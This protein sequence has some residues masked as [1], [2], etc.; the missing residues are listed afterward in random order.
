MLE[1]W[2][3][4][5]RPAGDQ[6]GPGK[7]NSQTCDLPQDYFLGYHA[8]SAF[9]GRNCK[10]NH[11]LPLVRYNATKFGLRKK[12]KGMERQRQAKGNKGRYKKEIIMSK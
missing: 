12:I 7:N 6:A 4:T 2:R 5:E 10:V 8:V 11:E 1:A 9:H 3:E